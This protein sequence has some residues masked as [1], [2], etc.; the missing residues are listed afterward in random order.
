MKQRGFTLIELI[1]TIAMISILATV[2]A[3]TV[4]KGP[5]EHGRDSR[6]I[7]DLLSIQKAMEQC[8]NLLGNQY[9]TGLPFGSQLPCGGETVLDPVPRD[10]KYPSSNYAASLLTS[11]DYCVCG[12]LECKQANSLD[13]NCTFT[14]ITPTPGAYG[15][16]FCVK[17]S[18]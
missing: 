2:L 5:S 10:P 14:G 11:S 12:T 3:L 4:Y 6:R 17:N 18:Q 15:G 16:Y 9:P 1:V 8:Y 7:Q 13:S